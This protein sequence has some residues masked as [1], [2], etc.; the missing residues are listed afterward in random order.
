MEGLALGPRL[1]NGNWVLLGVVDDGD[2]FSNNTLVALELVSSADADFDQDTD[3]DG[4]DF[5]IW[6]RGL[7]TGSTQAEGDANADGLVDE[8]DLAA[9]QW[10]IPAVGSGGIGGTQ[11]LAPVPEP[12]TSLLLVAGAF[13]I[14]A[15]ACR[16]RGN[17]RCT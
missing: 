3:I 5:L 10:S 9:W 2:P 11:Q 15:G 16:N 17:R 7:G 4:A 12:T 8:K 6:Q 13:A 1:P 14:I